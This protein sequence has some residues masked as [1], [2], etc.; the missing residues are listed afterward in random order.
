MQKIPKV[1]QVVPISHPG[2]TSILRLKEI[3]D[4]EDRKC[5]R[6]GKAKDETK[7]VKRLPKDADHMM[8]RGTETNKMSNIIR[9]QCLNNCFE[10]LSLTE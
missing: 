10:Q 8:I 6:K 2:R 3:L 4:E 9:E 1:S 5:K 7:E